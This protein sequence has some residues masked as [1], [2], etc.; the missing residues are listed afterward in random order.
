MPLSGKAM[1]RL[2]S[3]RGWDLVRI[4]GSHHIMQLGS[5]K[6]SVPVHGNKSL[7]KGLEKKLLKEAGV[8][9]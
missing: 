7:G 2:L 1:V 3:K 9:K 5:K 6:V 4:K 8:E